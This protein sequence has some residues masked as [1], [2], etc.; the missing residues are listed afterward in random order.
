MKIDKGKEY[1]HK[2]L[3]ISCKISILSTDYDWKVISHIIQTIYKIPLKK[4]LM[5]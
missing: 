3:Y 2:I 5:T 1:V 4:L